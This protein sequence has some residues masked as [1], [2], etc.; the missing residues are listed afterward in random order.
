MGSGGEQCLLTFASQNAIQ[1]ELEFRILK[2][3][4]LHTTIAMANPGTRIAMQSLWPPARAQQA[5]RRRSGATKA[6]H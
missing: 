5:I 2:V 4:A 1:R 3:A 6:N